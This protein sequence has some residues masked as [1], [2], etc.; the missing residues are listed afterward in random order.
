MG[1]VKRLIGGLSLTAVALLTA[2][3]WAATAERVGV[4]TNLEGMA[5]VTR[6]ALPEPRLLQFKDDVFVRDRI[7]TGER[8]IV[9]VLLGG[10]ATVTAR[11]RSV[12]TIT[13]V[14][15]V[16]N[17]ELGA[18]RI[19]VAVAKGSMK[20]GEIIEIRTPNAVTA[21]RGT[22]VVAEVFP[23]Q[24]VRSTI[25]V[26]RGLIDVT[27]LD[28]GRRVGLSVNVGALQSITVMGSNPLTHPTAITA[29]E[30]KRLT[31]EFRIVP[32]RVHPAATA[33]A[34]ER[35]MQQA[36]ADAEALISSGSTAGSAAGTSTAN[37]RDGASGSS[38]DSGSS[39]YSGS[40]GSGSS[41]YSG[42][43]GSGSSGYS[44]SSGSGS[45]GYSG[46]SGSGSSG[47]SGSSGSG[48]SGYSG[49]SG[50]GSSGYSGSSGS[51]SSGY[52]GSS[53]SGSSGHSGSSGSGSSGSGGGSSKRR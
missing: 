4:V 19:S 16:S 36:T 43:S 48:S 12:L 11:E 34:F 8:S 49:S 42:S 31:S 14:P 25:S 10:K 30:A 20:P 17:I 37:N 24:S 3:P 47:Y 21:I 53:G 41:G 18:G 52:S 15:G 44:G 1:L 13:E 33:P 9:R 38:N 39:G 46:S 22:V 6:V 50:S 45:S 51:G 2:P 29:D 27:R 23:A 26:L 40:S 7:T 28:T 5:T 35:A 32:S